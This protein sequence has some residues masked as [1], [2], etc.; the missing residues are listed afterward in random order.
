MFCPQEVLKTIWLSSFI[1]RDYISSA[2]L[3]AGGPGTTW[4][5][6]AL[7]LAVF[8]PPTWQS[9]VLSAGGPGTYLAEFCIQFIPPR[10]QSAVLS[11]GGP[12]LSGNTW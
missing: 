9:P 10:W 11:A 7:S 2:V 8:I 6:F 3:P 4:Q 5:S 1:S 12:G